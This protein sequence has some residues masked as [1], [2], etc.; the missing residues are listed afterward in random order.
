MNIKTLKEMN[1]S[2]S[3]FD[4]ERAELCSTLENY[5][6]SQNIETQERKQ[7]KQILGQ[8][9]NCPLKC[10]LYNTIH[11]VYCLYAFGVV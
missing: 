5:K 7:C 10:A 8:H 1:E 2:Q 3:H 9:I 11:C 6:V 4:K